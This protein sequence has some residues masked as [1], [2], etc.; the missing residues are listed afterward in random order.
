M[1]FAF[2]INFLHE[3]TNFLYLFL[4][5]CHNVYKLGGKPLSENKRKEI[6]SVI[7][8][9]LSQ[10]FYYVGSRLK[11]DKKKWLC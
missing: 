2:C 4:T 6:N 8:S 3:I 1:I 11:K 5:D 9:A 7:R 10:K